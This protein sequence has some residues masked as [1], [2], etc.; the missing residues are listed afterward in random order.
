MADTRGS[1]PI[2]AALLELVSSTGDL[3]NRYGRS[4]CSRSRLHLTLDNLCR[5]LWK[6]GDQL[7][8]ITGTLQTAGLA[9]DQYLARTVLVF[10]FGKGES[11]GKTKNA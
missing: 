10:A 6:A 11:R 8:C 5:D 4:C 2:V 3:H 9:N 7:A 1:L